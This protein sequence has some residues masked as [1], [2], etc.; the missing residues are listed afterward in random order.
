MTMRLFSNLR[1]ILLVIFLFTGNVTVVTGED[2]NHKASWICKID[3]LK[4]LL[5][6]P[7]SEKQKM[8]IYYEIS[9]KYNSYEQDST[10]AYANKAIAVALNLNDQTIL[11][12]FYV[13]IGVA[14]CFKNNYDSA[15]IY[16]YRAE[17]SAVKQ[18]NKEKEITA[19]SMIAFGYAKQGKYNTAIDYFLKVLKMSDNDRESERYI[20]ALV[21]LCEINRRLGNT[22]IAIQYL[23]RAEVKCKQ[24]GES[25][26][27]WRMPHIY[28]EYA[29]NYL[30]RGNLD[31]ALRYAL[32]AEN[33]NCGV[34]NFCYTKGLLATIYLQKNDFD[35]ALQYAEESYEQADILKDNNLYAYSG[36]ILSDVFMEQK[37]FPEAE[38]EA[39]T[40]WQSDSTNID[41][42][43]E[44]VEN[45][46]LANIFMGN[47][48]KAAYY[49]KKF[50]ELNRLYSKKS[51]QTTVSDL[52]VKYETEK[53]E[54]QI[55]SLEKQRILYIITGIIGVLLAIIVGLVSWHKIRREQLKKQLIAT[56][57]VL[58]W[59]EKER[60]RFA[61]EL[62]D[63]INSMLSALKIGLDTTGHHMQNV[64]DKLDECIE[65]I[66]RM[67]H[68]LMPASLE[69]FGM[70]AALEDHCRL[71]P[72]VHFYFFGEDRRV[73]KK[74]ELVIFYCAYELVNNSAKH[75][76]AKNTNVQLVQGEKY[77]SLT[78][79]DDGCGFNM[80]AVAQGSG[81]KNISNRV[82]SCNGKIDIA[83]SPGAG[84][85]TIIELR[86]EN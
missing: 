68:G 35:R 83:S 65:T 36:K 15:Y 48:E 70:K 28:N 42:S 77:V 16:L 2:D 61:N 74:V 69:R 58:E 80:D 29:F 9:D 46:A 8:E 76:G 20:M 33:A 18:G 82:I 53:K 30:E 26:F 66:R 47:K 37:H 31:E 40:V 4:L 57:A 38:A 14:Y 45:M 44:V 63:G 71:F 19:L 6:Q 51:F 7:L 10:I 64:G 24:L 85:E 55:S 54:M 72:N 73:E 27:R 39:L 25:H 21:N 17:E 56:N 52:A 78:V 81:L 41:E 32:K 62:H 43:R 50:S 3:S 1:N 23:N 79:Q 75:S 13:K 12:D 11:P 5:N 84:T 59:E 60:K 67:A 34:V 86:I 22:E 49:L